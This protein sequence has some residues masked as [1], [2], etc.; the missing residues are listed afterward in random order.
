[1]KRSPFER[2][3]DT[4]PELEVWW[5]SSPLIYSSWA[6]GLLKK[7]PPQ[8]M[9]EVREQL[10]RLYDP[11]HPEK[12]LFRGVTTNPPL[13]LNVIKTREAYVA[14]IVDGLIEKNPCVDREALFW[15]TY[16]EIVRRG[17]EMYLGVFERSRYRYGYLSGQVDPRNLTD[18]EKMISQALE[19]ASLSPNVMIKVPGSREGYEVIKILTSKGISTNNTLTFV[20]PQLMACAKAV[21]EGVEMAK[22]NGVDLTRW[23]SVIT[24][25][26]ARYGDLGDLRKE[27]ES[28][29]IDLSEADVRWA[30]IAIFKKAYWLLKERN[31][32]S[33]MLLCSMRISPEQDGKKHCWH[34]EK[35]AGG[36]IVFTCPPSFIEGVFEYLDGIEFRPQIDEEVPRAVLERLLRIPYF[37]K[38]Y[39]EN[40]LMPDE[41]NAHPALIVTAKEFSKT[42]EEMV[43]FVAKRLATK[44][45]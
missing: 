43:E 36:D 17:A 28:M 16:K 35:L 33:K 18:K 24:H 27:A 38:A 31:Y 25:M 7:V 20:L 6:E 23:R 13:S 1:M 12:T 39:D 14:Q 44:C 5:D 21:R 45:G 30:E 29:E 4:H 41:F 26:T 34:L 42:T 10:N 37:E 8:R 32:P 19:L 22:Q 11:E 9:E 3:M 40:G 15:L 2:L